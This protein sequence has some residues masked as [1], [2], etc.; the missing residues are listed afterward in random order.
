[1][2]VDD[3]AGGN[4]TLDASAMTTNVRPICWSS[5]TSAGFTSSD[6]IVGDAATNTIQ[7]TDTGSF[8]LNDAS[9]TQVQGIEVLKIGGTGTDTL[10]L[11]WRWPV[12]RSAGWATP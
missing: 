3:T 6:H 10:N 5:W 4:L 1:M 8:T 7:L 2:T 12:R 9:F 11:G